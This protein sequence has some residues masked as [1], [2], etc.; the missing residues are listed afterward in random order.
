MVALKLALVGL[1][2]YGAFYPSE[3]SGGMRKR[4]SLARAIA[5][6]FGGA[7]RSTL[8]MTATTSLYAVDV[9]VTGAPR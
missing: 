8:F 1:D 5:L 2:G 4:A 9:A 3:I 6:E 7:G